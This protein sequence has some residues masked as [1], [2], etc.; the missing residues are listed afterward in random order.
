M[1]LTLEAL[2]RQTKNNADTA[3]RMGS[4]LAPKTAE[5][6]LPAL[7]GRVLTDFIN[8][9]KMVPDGHYALRRANGELDF[10]EVVTRGNRNW[11]TT[12]IGAPGD[13]R[14]IRMSYELMMWAARN[15]A[16]D[17]AAAAKTYADEHRV[18]ARCD[19]P[20]TDAT[21]RDLGLGPVCR[22]YYA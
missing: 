17:P 10:L 13:W 6:Q 4:V 7:T 5:R 18:C 3:T 2:R 12:L 16:R 19:S 9:V 11:V 15:I 22:K 8:A 21:S 1:N 14:R 20:L